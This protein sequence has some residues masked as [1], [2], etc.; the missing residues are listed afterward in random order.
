MA[1]RCRPSTPWMI[2]AW[3]VRPAKPKPMRPTSMVEG[4]RSVLLGRNVHVNVN[5]PSEGGETRRDRRP[6]TFSWQKERGGNCP[7][8][9]SREC[10]TLVK[11]L[12]GR[13]RSAT[14]KGAVAGRRSNANIHRLRSNPLESRNHLV[15]TRQQP[16]W[17]VL[18]GICLSINPGTCERWHGRDEARSIDGRRL[19]RIR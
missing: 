10:F 7:P 17:L 6:P 2:G 4:K 5:T 3:N 16:A 15:G 13:L 19:R 18:G 1:A 9:L 8:L 12:C 11:I 14:A